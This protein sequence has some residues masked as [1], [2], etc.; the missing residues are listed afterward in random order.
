MKKLFGRRSVD[1]ITNI[2]VDTKHLTLRVVL[3]SVFLVLG[4]GAIIYGLTGLFSDEGG[5]QIIE[6]EPYASAD[7]SDEFTLQYEL[8]AG[9]ISPK[10]EYNQLSALYGEAAAK[11][12]Q[13]FHENQ[14]FDGICN[15][16]Y[17]NEHPNET[18]EVDSVLYDAF[19][20]LDKAGSRQLFAAP[21]W[22]YYNV[23]FSCGEDW[24]IESYDP[25]LNE[26]LAQL[27]AETSGYIN[28]P[29]AV[30][31]ELCGNNKVCLRVSEEY[32]RFAEENDIYCFISFHF[33][34]NAFIIDYIA[35]KLIQSG[36]THGTISS[37]DG[38]Y[39]DL[40]DRGTFYS[41]NLFDRNGNAVVCAATLDYSK[42]L[43][44]VSLRA[45]PVSEEDSSRY[46]VTEKGEI[47]FPYIDTVR[48]ICLAAN[49][50]LVCYS[51]D[52]GCAELLLQAIPVYI[53]ES[54]QPELLTCEFIY[55]KEGVIYYSEE[56]V[57]LSDVFKGYGT[58]FV[59]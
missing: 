50:G 4:I 37:F 11:M 15:V 1:D 43:N 56:T 49:D 39:R 36:Y 28:D 55:C 34:K 32:L 2:E 31:L 6:A 14:L 21:Y 54:F 42:R 29:K 46:Y 5:W 30:S 48:G 45:F 23:L 33:M 20:M 16:A 51:D 26:E 24:E 53:A 27:F 57:E 47:R 35:D 58:R 9:D 7:C 19:E 22:E 12:Y 52:A 17:L 13:L 8:G 41:L 59:E 10:T 44:I 40:D 25:T 38:F 3:F 18:A